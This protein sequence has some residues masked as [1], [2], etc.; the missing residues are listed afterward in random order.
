MPLPFMR[1]RRHSWAPPAGSGAITV[2]AAHGGTVLV[3]CGATLHHL[4]VA[5]PD[6]Y[7][8]VDGPITHVA[9]AVSR[10]QVASLAVFSMP[11]AH[12]DAAGGHGPQ[13]CRVGA[14]RT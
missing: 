7:G 10:E 3:A 8:E 2:A 9:S 13:V 11:A 6:A 1:G 5:E 12:A 14:G 4:Q